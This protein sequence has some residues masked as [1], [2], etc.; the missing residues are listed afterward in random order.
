MLNILHPY[1]LWMFHKG[2]YL[3]RHH[4]MFTR[5]KMTWSNLG[6]SMDAGRWPGQ[7][8]DIPSCTIRQLSMWDTTTWC[9]QR[10]AVHLISL[11]ASQRSASHKRNISSI[12][13][14]SWSSPTL[15]ASNDHRVCLFLIYD[16]TPSLLYF[17]NAI[18]VGVYQSSNPW[19]NILII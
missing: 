17:K 3:V 7:A 2:W 16:I 1:W 5:L 9:R 8:L 11:A 12:A 6:W 4:L 18:I 10:D 14:V 19:G 15:V 13:E